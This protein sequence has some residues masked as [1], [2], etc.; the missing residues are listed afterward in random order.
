MCSHQCVLGYWERK[1]KTKRWKLEIYYVMEKTINILVKQLVSIAIYNKVIFNNINYNRIFPYFGFWEVSTNTM[2]RDLI[3]NDLC[4][5]GAIEK[6]LGLNLIL[7]HLNRK[8]PTWECAAV[9]TREFYWLLLWRVFISLPFN[10]LDGG[11]STLLCSSAVVWFS[12][13]AILRVC[14]WSVLVIMGPRWSSD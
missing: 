1:S 8:M 11:S 12:C 9:I 7:S 4:K 14:P 6:L 3:T 10:I 2:Q 5:P 13:S